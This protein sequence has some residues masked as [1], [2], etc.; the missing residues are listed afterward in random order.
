MKVHFVCTGN[1]CRSPMAEALLRHALAARD[2][3]ADVEVT[4]SGTWADIGSPATSG[5]SDA[6]ARRG[7]DLREHRSRPVD[8]EELDAADVVVVMTS[9][10]VREVLEVTP[11]VRPKL[12]LLKELPEM[13]AALTAETHS[14]DSAQARLSQ[15]LGAQRPEPRRSLD[16]DDPIGLPFMAYDRCVDDLLRGIEVLAEVLC[17]GPAQG[18]T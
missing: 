13:L 3:P 8:P 6:L 5:A 4:S 14:D 17:G 18:D 1:L 12:V 9:V 11:A 2:C 10:H 7:V 15:L 16:V